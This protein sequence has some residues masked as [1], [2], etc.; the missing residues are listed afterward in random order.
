[1]YLSGLFI[2]RFDYDRIQQLLK[3]FEYPA[4][5]ENRDSH[6]FI[7]SRLAASPPG[8]GSLT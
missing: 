7:F 4:Q 8:R 6:Y 5:G 3:T 2:G 1:V